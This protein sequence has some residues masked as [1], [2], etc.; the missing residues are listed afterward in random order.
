MHQC[1]LPGVGFIFR[2]VLLLTML[3]WSTLRT[4]TCSWVFDFLGGKFIQ[5]P[6]VLCPHTTPIPVL[7]AHWS[8]HSALMHRDATQ[9]QL[10]SVAET[11]GTRLKTHTDIFT[12]ASYMGNLWK[13]YVY[14]VLEKHMLASLML[15]GLFSF[16]VF[17]FLIWFSVPTSLTPRPIKL[18]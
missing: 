4:L 16:Y 5:R 11:K 9:R 3:I 12:T 7:L 2:L 17:K 15:L 6:T 1:C 13:D 8:F 14:F 18:L 10:F